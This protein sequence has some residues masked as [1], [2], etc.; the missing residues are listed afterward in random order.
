VDQFGF[1][2]VSGTSHHEIGNSDSHYGQATTGN[3]GR[4]R[5]FAWACSKE[6]SEY[7]TNGNHNNNLGSVVV[8]CLC[9]NLIHLS[10]G[11]F[12]SHNYFHLDPF[13]LPPIA[14]NL[15]PLRTKIKAT[16]QQ[17]LP[18]SKCVPGRHFPSPRRQAHDF[19]VGMRS[20]ASHF[21]SFCFGV[22]GVLAVKSFFALIREIRVRFSFPHSQTPDPRP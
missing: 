21:N 7:S 20:T 12:V 17:F 9:L 16:D 15:N 22:L 19:M 8:R 5:R 10:N 11:F 6:E 13:I 1:S 3:G 2:G 14:Q 4:P 18:T